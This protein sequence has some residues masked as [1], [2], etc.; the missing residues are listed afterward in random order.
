MSQ[1]T[2]TYKLGNE[3]FFAYARLVRS[4]NFSLG[5]RILRILFWM[6]I[7]VSLVVFSKQTTDPLFTTIT[8]L[9]GFGAA[10]MVLVFINQEQQKLIPSSM[11]GQKILTFS[12]ME[13][14]DES[15]SVKQVISWDTIDSVVS[16]KK[17]LFVFL[18]KVAAIIIPKSQLGGQAVETIVEVLKT[19]D[20]LIETSN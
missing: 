8:F 10:F 18:D 20:V 16:T 11:L 5:N 4:R 1:K 13:I 14:V 12:D 6:V 19:K 15:K 9:L 17:H 2:F 3:D 7:G